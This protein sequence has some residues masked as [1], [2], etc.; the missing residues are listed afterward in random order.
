MLF[1]RIVSSS[2]LVFFYLDY[3]VFRVKK[4]FDIV[5]KNQHKKYIEHPLAPTLIARTHVISLNTLPG[6][7]ILNV[8]ASVKPV[9]DEFGDRVGRVRVIAHCRVVP[10]ETI[11]MRT[12]RV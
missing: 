5:I 8:V 9:P 2:W 12:A 4:R 1:K 6:Q 3:V 7:Q 10:V 11:G